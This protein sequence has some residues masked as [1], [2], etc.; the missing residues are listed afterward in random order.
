MNVNGM[1]QQ[2]LKSACDRLDVAI[3]LA[4]DELAEFTRVWR[5]YEG[6]LTV[7]ELSALV[8]A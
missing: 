8:G 5:D 3:D 2:E 4:V 1:T 6:D 7:R